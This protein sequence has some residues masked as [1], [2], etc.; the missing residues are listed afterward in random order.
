M[1]G[2]DAFWGILVGAIVFGVIIA[3]ITLITMV[4]RDNSACIANGGIPYTAD[5]GPNNGQG[6]CFPKDMVKYNIKYRED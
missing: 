2:K 5:D 1:K 4:S 3:V 6:Y